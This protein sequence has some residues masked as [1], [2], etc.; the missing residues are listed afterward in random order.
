MKRTPTIAQIGIMLIALGT[1]AVT[2][3]VAWQRI[4]DT[5]TTETAEGAGLSAAVKIGGPFALTNHL[6]EKVSDAVYRGQYLY[7]YFGYGYCPDVCPTE[8]ANMAATIDALGLQADKVQPLFITID[9]ERDTT[10]FLAEYVAQFHPRFIGLTGSLAEIAAV[11]KSYRVFYRKAKDEDA[12]EYLMDHSNFV[13]FM[14][15]DGGF[16]TMFRGGTDPEAVAKTMT[17]YIQKGQS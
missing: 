17:K 16:L 4:A 9:P 7:I 8:L 6:G 15:D 11:A 10:Q 14:G 2:A 12:S 3:F 1:I 13:Y 5:R